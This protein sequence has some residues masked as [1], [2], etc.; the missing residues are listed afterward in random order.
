MLYLAHHQR[1][2]Y[3][4]LY[5]KLEYYDSL[6]LNSKNRRKFGRNTKLFVRFLIY[7]VIPARNLLMVANLLLIINLNLLKQSTVLLISSI[8]WFPPSIWIIKYVA[9]LMLTTFYY[10][11]ITSLYL[12]LRFRQITDNLR[13]LINSRGKRKISTRLFL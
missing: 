12:N 3:L 4:N 7:M 9:A 1:A 11:Y 2:L 8:L 6:E 10:I 13:I 5:D